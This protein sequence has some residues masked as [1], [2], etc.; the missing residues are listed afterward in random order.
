MKKYFVMAASLFASIAS[1]SSP[2]TV[3][4]TDM[5]EGIFTVFKTT[6]DASGITLHLNNR[7]SGLT[8]ARDLG[9]VSDGQRPPA[10][11]D[12]VY[13]P[14]ECKFSISTAG[15]PLLRCSGGITLNFSAAK[16]LAP[17]NAQLDIE[18]TLNHIEAVDYSYDENVLTVSVYDQ[19]TQKSGRQEFTFQQ[20]C[21]AN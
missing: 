5:G 2:S 18:L 17:V 11:L 20:G 15:Q 13:T 9:L 8:I 7:I 10:S 6:S 21:T 4:C 14:N 19:T 1:A 3:G 12:A 16:P